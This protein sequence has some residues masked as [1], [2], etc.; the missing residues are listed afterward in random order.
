L[1][2]PLRLNSDFNE[3]SVRATVEDTYG[4]IISDLKQARALLPKLIPDSPLYKLRVNTAA[5]NAMLARVYLAMEDY[6]NAFIYADE[7]LKLYNTLMDYNKFVVPSTGNPIPQ[8]NSEVIYFKAMINYGF[9]ATA[10]LIVDPSLFASY[11]PND[12]RKNC[13]FFLSSGNQAF[14]G[15]YNVNASKFFGGIATD[16]VYLIRAECNA[17]K[18]KKDDAL[19]DLNTLME[20]RWKAAAWTPFTATDANDALSKV[21]KERRKELV[22]R[23]LRWTDLRRLNQDSRFAMTLS[24]TVMGQTYTLPPNDIR[25]VLPIPDNVILLSGIQQNPR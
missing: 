2:I 13:Y 9:F 5:A 1:G 25:Y 21:L 23:G 20:K 16:E 11:D 6:D 18:G 7:C 17:R 15:G 14:R 3:R 19:K 22:F 10:R 8:F 4:Q 12:L 24:R